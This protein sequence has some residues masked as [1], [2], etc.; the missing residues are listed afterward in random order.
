D[1]E[2]AVAKQEREAA[3]QKRKEAKAAWE[4]AERAWAEADKRVKAVSA[5]RRLFFEE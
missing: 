2:W 3:H 1:G 5:E 4:E